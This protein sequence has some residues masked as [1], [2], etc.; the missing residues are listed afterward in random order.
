MIELIGKT[1]GKVW[2]SLTDQGEMSLSQLK[3]SVVGIYCQN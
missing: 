2:E 3:K 1:A